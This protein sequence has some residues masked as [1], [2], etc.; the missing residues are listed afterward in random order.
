M[1]R[2]YRRRM[3]PPGMKN[4]EVVIEESDLY[5]LADTDIRER[6]FCALEKV[7]FDLKN[8]IKNDPLFQTT[9]KAHNV[10]DNAPAIVREMAEV[11]SVFDVGPMASVAGAVAKYVGMSLDPYCSRLIIENGGD[12]YIKSSEP[13]VSGIW[14]GEHSPFSDKLKFRVDPGGKPLGICTSSR[15]VGPS[16][17]LGNADAVVTIAEC[18]IVADAA[19]TFAGNMVKCA[20]DIETAIN[21]EIEYNMLKGIIIIIGDRIGA[22]GDFEF[23]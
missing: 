3:N 14:A 15:T 22:E 21:K 6:A 20:D 5:I 4:F 17:S 9:L 23:I 10:P 2:F 16:L 18:P 11:T 8:Y 13:V 12:I 7:R 19:A 1:D